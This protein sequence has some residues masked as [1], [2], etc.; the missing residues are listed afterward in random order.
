MAPGILANHI[1]FR[2]FS[3]KIWC[4]TNG[5]F[6]DRFR[7]SVGKKS[8][9]KTKSE[10]WPRWPRRSWRLTYKISHFGIHLG[11]HGLWRLAFKRNW[12]FDKCS[13]IETYVCWT[14]LWTMKT[15]WFRIHPSL[16]TLTFCNEN[17]A[18][19]SATLMV[20]WRIDVCKKDH[21]WR[22]SLSNNSHLGG[23]LAIVAAVVSD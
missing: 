3:N 21:H 14:T 8:G 9:L 22:G 16:R 2:L 7:F 10:T 20:V 11:G 18:N 12:D 6:N 13:C 23:N 19:L 4:Q 15:L 17:D 1:F 5:F